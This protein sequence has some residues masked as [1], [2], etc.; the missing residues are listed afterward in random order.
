MSSLLY[1]SPNTNE[2]LTRDIAY[3]SGS[4][5]LT[6]LG[7][8]LGVPLIHSHFTRTTYQSVTDKFQQRLSAWKCRTLSLSGRI[9]YIQA[10]MLVIPIY[11][12]QIVLL[13]ISICKML[14]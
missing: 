9:T 1:C 6:D 10:V 5:F 2:N 4:L 3:I 8:Y 7:S 12:M 13:P 14:E 11:T